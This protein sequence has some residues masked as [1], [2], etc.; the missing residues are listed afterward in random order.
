MMMALYILAEQSQ[1]SSDSVE[2]L[3]TMLNILLLMKQQP[4]SLETFRSLHAL[5]ISLGSGLPMGSGGRDT[6]DVE[7]KRRFRCQI[8]RLSL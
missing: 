2:V 5:C 8:E 3:Q 4:G 7:V 6:V 1:V